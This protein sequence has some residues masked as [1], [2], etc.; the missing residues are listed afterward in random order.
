[1][2]FHRWAIKKHHTRD[3]VNIVYPGILL[4]TVLTATGL[5]WQE[6]PPR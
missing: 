3:A 6:Y 5:P 4:I 2:S 1:M